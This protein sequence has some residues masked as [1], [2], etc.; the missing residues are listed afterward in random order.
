[1]IEREGLVGSFKEENLTRIHFIDSPN[2]D[3]DYKV[4]DFVEVFCDHEDGTNRVRGWLKGVVVQADTKMIA[5][6]FQEKVY[7]TDGWMVPDH[8]LWTP[9][10]STSIRRYN[11]N[12][13]RKPVT[14]KIL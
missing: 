12:I 6:Q 8:V 7:L 5:I 1:M 3:D 4:G 13:R 9:R 10:T 2:S 11:P 14:K